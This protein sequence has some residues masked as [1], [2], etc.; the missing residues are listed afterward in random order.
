M[1]LRKVRLGIAPRTNELML[2]E[3]SPDGST[4]K[5]KRIMTWETMRATVQYANAN[6]LREVEVW[7]GADKYRVQ[8]S[9]IQ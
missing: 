6:G 7:M 2:Y 8:I 5:D 4:V 1:D 3:Y 9:K